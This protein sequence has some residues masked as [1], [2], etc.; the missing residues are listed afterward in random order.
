MARTLPLET[1]DPLETDPEIKVHTYQV[2]RC[3]FMVFDNTSSP[4]DDRRVRQ[5]LNYAVDREVIVKSLLE[6][7]GEP[8]VGPFPSSIEEWHNPDLDGYSHDLDRARTLLSEAGW[9]NDDEGQLRSRDGEDLSI[10]IM[11]YES[12]PLLPQVTEVLQDQFDAVGVNVDLSVLEYTA[13]M[14]Q[15]Q[16]GAFDCYLMTMSMLWYPDPERLGDVY[17]S[18]G[19]MLNHGYANDDVD[20]LLAA[21]REITDRSERAER[22]RQLQSIVLEDAPL[23]YLTYYTNVIATSTNVQGYEPHPTE[24]TYGLQ[25]IDVNSDE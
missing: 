15:A 13:M 20:E 21:A 8:A 14:E 10:E 19:S 18:E 1:A 6:G 17:H 22:Y 23:A 24:T 2:P 4:F 7:I 16:Q 12:R 25:S 5:A 11:T 9:T 3:R